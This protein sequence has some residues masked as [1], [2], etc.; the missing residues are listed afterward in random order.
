MVREMPR[1]IGVLLAALAILPTLAPMIVYPQP[2]LFSVESLSFRSSTG[3]DV[4]AGS[5]NARL[6]V[7][8]RYLGASRLGPSRAAWTSPGAS[9]HSTGARALGTSTVRT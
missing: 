2:N 7:G 4:Y 9:R 5:S 6:V 8:V 3:G 1:G